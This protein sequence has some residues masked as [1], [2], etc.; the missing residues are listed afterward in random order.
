MHLLT[1]VMRITLVSSSSKK[2]F[3]IYSILKMSKNIKD[4]TGL[5]IFDFKSLLIENLTVL[6]KNELINNQPFKVKA[7]EVVLK[8]LEEYPGVIRNYQDIEDAKFK[9][10]GKKIEAKIKEIFSTGRLSAVQRAKESNPLDLYDQILEVY[11]IGP[12]KAKELIEDFAVV[13]IEDLQEKSKLYPNLLSYASK[14]GLVHYYDFKERIPRNEMEVHDM[15]IHNFLPEKNGK[16]VFKAEIAG[17]YRR[18]LPNSGDIDVLLTVEKVGYF[19][20]HHKHD[21]PKDMSKKDISLF[22]DYINELKEIGYITDILSLGSNKCLAVCK[23]DSKYRR[24]DF[25][26]TMFDTY[27]YSL[28]YFTG[29]KQFNVAMRGYALK[30]GWS[31]NQQG[32][33]RM[34]GLGPGP[35]IVKSEKDIFDFLGLLYVKPEHRNGIENII[36]K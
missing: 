31:L 10:I 21:V 28:L 30:K 11:G 9:G 34:N 2:V 24:I 12:V 33:E 16:T 23:I 18:G 19:R 29:S 1:F 15:V 22:H 25:E 14:V 4:Y 32:L 35:G 6:K 3:N 26:L 27:Y 20:E 5:K 36:E 8:Q 7:Y 17:S 13:S